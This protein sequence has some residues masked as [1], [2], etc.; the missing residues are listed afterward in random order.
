M[1]ERLQF[2]YDSYKSLMGD[3]WNETQ[4]LEQAKFLADKEKSIRKGDNILHIDYLK[5]ILS[6]DD[7]QEF[8]L[9][10]KGI[11]LQLSSYDKS[12]VHYASLDDLTG[13]VRQILSS[14]VTQD[15]LIGVVGS[16]VW[17]GLC[18]IWNAT[19]KKI[20][21]KKITKFSAGKT[22]STKDVT[23]SIVLK[24]NETTSIEYNLRGN[25]K[26]DIETYETFNKILENAKQQTL[27]KI[28]RR[29]LI[30]EANFNTKSVHL[31]DE[32][33][34]FQDKIK[35]QKKRESV[36]RKKKKK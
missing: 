27:N 8:E 11:G 2:Y 32:E 29:P 17:D 21:G 34:F 1:D 10:L 18:K 16:A 5:G 7:L 6:Q 4:I 28:P 22:K 31:I 25:S 30:A 26:N 20:Q 13:V 12:G 3:T 19:Y 24:L 36:K 35:E 9:T 33:K 23:M 14:N 15:I